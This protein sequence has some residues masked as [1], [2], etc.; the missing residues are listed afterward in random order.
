VFGA[1]AQVAADAAERKGADVTP[2]RDL[3]ADRD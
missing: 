1:I 3:L 2:V